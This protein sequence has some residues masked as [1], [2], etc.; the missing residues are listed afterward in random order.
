MAPPD[1]SPENGTVC[2]KIKYD[3]IEEISI[4]GEGS[5]GQVFKGKWRGIYVAMKRVSQGLDD[6]EDG[7]SIEI[8]QLSRTSHENI[9]KL[10]GA[11][12]DKKI[13]VLE[14]ADG[15]SLYKLLHGSKCHY[16]LGHAMS[17]VYQCAKGVEYLHLMKPTPLIHRDLKPPNLLLFKNRLHLKICDFGTVADK[18]TYMT[19]NKGSAAWMA[20][21][22]FSTSNYIEKCDVYSWSIIFWEVLSR[23]IPFNRKAHTL[24]VLWSV[25][26]GKR[27]PTL[28]NCPEIIAKLIVQ[29]WG[30]VP[31][32]RPTMTQI[33]QIMEALMK[34]VPKDLEPVVSEY[35][36]L[37]DE[38][39]EDYYENE[40]D[41]NIY[42][43]IDPFMNGNNSE[44]RTPS[45]PQPNESMFQPLKV[46]V[47]QNDW[48][49]GDECLMKT[50]PGFDVLRNGASNSVQSGMQSSNVTQTVSNVDNL[51]PDIVMQLLDPHLRP[52]TPDNNDP[53]SIALYERHLQL[54]EELCKVQTET[55]LLSAKRQQLLAQKTE[56]QQLRETKERLLKDKQS[57]LE[58]KKYLE[59]VKQSQPNQVPDDWVI[60]NSTDNR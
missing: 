10:Y 29:C 25:Y 2:E 57:W 47:D 41:E 5:F 18:R 59:G 38:D 26:Q 9:V 42:E 56:E 53:M 39:Y 32:K 8:R 45:L 6:K 3:D 30:P 46:D 11:C 23:R 49:D 21:E 48:G 35:E 4:I 58:T 40:D 27:P 54:A 1:V 37:Y 22:V 55:A 51:D 16:N 20:P 44:I 24:S 52:A 50:M 31:E 12:I 43:E 33:V 14:Y 19:N 60:V 34:Y 36:Y 7:F 17:W 28:K 13:L 15:G